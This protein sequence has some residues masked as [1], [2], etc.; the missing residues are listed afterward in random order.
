MEEPLHVLLQSGHPL[1]DDDM[2]AL[3]R[4]M[5]FKQE[6]ILERVSGLEKQANAGFP[7]GDPVLHRMYHDGIIERTQELRKLRQAIQEKTILALIFAGGVWLFHAVL[8]SL[9][10]ALGMKIG[11]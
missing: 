10:E 2:S 8:K 7:G 4:M 11:G 1:S 5:L 6:E 9:G 3:L